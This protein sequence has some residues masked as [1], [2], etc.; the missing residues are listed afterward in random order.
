MRL[1]QVTIKN[2]KSIKDETVDIKNMN[3][4]VGKNGSGKTNVLEFFKLM[5]LALT[6]E[7]VPYNP[8]SPWRGYQN[9]VW[10]KNIE[11]NVSGRFIFELEEREQIKDQRSMATLNLQGK[12]IIY[13]LS[14]GQYPYGEL[15]IVFEQLEIEGILK[16]SKAGNNVSITYEKDYYEKVIKPQVDEIQKFIS[17]LKRNERD[18]DIFKELKSISNEIE[19]Q[20]K[21]FESRQFETIRNSIL[22]GLFIDYQ[23][24]EDKTIKKEPIVFFRGTLLE[25]FRFTAS[26]LRKPLGREILDFFSR[27]TLLRPPDLRKIRESAFPRDTGNLKEDGSNLAPVLYRLLDM[28]GARKYKEIKKAIE[29]FFENAEFSFDFTKDGRIMLVVKENELE[30]H[31]HGIGTGFYKLLFV[32]T[33]LFSR[34]SLLLVDE[35]ENSLHFE[36]IQFLLDTIID[37]GVQTIISTHSPIIVD[38]LDLDHFLICEKE[39]VETKLRRLKNIE[40][41]KQKLQEEGL[42]HSDYWMADGF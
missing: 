32:L 34:P 35:F 10:Q 14:L 6:E 27:I 13:E 38:M 36:A 15:G 24:T 41:L 17:E 21:N 16:A 37:E 11:L 23:L 1:S 7:T 5:K 2:F 28:K 9:V 12:K 20:V 3:V 33:G 22:D 19:F 26:T 29:S 42:A 8:F 39:Q 25:R 18:N 4:L 30:L 31:P 40:I